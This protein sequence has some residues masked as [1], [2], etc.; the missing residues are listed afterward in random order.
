MKEFSGIRRLEHFDYSR[1]G[2]YFI[3]ICTNQRD[4]IFGKID[5]G[6]MNLS[7][8]GEMIEKEWLVLPERYSQLVL[9]EF[10]VMPNHFHAIVWIKERENTVGAPLVGASGKE[11]GDKPRAY[12]VLR[13]RTPAACPSGHAKG[14]ATRRGAWVR[15]NARMNL[16]PT[17]KDYMRMKWKYGIKGTSAGF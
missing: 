6:C 7:P 14:A 15:E 5:E 9:D 2:A 10:V 11:R 1:P 4:L 12:A 8:A 3:T 13:R 16:A 17:K